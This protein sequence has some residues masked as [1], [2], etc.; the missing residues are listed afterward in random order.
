MSDGINV[1]STFFSLLHSTSALGSC[2]MVKTLEADAEFIQTAPLICHNLHHQ[3][4]THVVMITVLIFL[5]VNVFISKL[6]FLLLSL[7]CSFL[8]FIC[9]TISSFHFCDLNV[10]LFINVSFFFRNHLWKWKLFFKSTWQ[11][12]MSCQVMIQPK[13]IGHSCRPKSFTC[14]SRFFFPPMSFSIPSVFLLNVSALSINDGLGSL[15]AAIEQRVLAFFSHWPVFHY[16]L[17]WHYSEL[18]PFSHSPVSFFLPHLPLI[19]RQLFRLRLSPDR[20]GASS[21]C[22]CVL[23]PAHV[24]MSVQF[25]LIVLFYNLSADST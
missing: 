3:H 21:E 6:R 16:N 12:Q 14:P 20:D 7:C 24:C 15:S 23:M 13:Y 25:I 5:I 10:L 11:H 4:S 18:W 1:S 8:L 9:F 17:L 2:W 22:I 19:K